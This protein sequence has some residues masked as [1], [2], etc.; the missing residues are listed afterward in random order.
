MDHDNKSD[1]FEALR[2]QA[3]ELIKQV[4]LEPHMESSH[5]FELIHELKQQQKALELQNEE[6][7]QKQREISDL[8]QEYENLY[9]LASIA[10]ISINAKGIITRVN[11]MAVQLLKT[12]RQ[13]LLRSGFSRFI[14]PEWQASYHASLKDSIKT[15]KKQRIELKLKTDSNHTLWVRADIEA[16]CD[17]AGQLL[18]WYLMLIDITLQKKTEAL[19]KKNQEELDAIYKNAPVLLMLVDKDRRVKKIN[20]YGEKLIGASAQDLI[21][22]RGGEAIRCLHQLHHPNGCGSQPACVPCPIN[23][24]V[25]DSFENGTTHEMKEV[26]LPLLKDNE[27]KE[28]TFLVSTVLLNSEEEREVL[29]S[30]V[31]IT[32]RKQM[33]K[34]LRE[35]EESYRSLFNNSTIAV[36]IT[37]FP[38]NI[39]KVNDKM[40]EISGYSHEELKKVSTDDI[41][42]DPNDR[43]KLIKTIKQ[44]GKVDNYECRIKDKE[45]EIHWAHMSV[46]II[47]YRGQ[48]ALLT[49]LIDITTVKE[50]EKSLRE[51]E[52]RYRTI[53]DNAP[54]GFHIRDLSQR[55]ID[56]NHASYHMHGYCRDEFMSLNINKYV[57]EKLLKKA[58]VFF[59]AIKKGKSVHAFGTNIKKDGT[60]FPVEVVVVPVSFNGKAHSLTIIQ[61]ISDREEA[62]KALMESNEKFKS[63]F[64]Q[65]PTDILIAGLDGTILDFNHDMSII[66]IPRKEIIG[67]K[68]SE[69]FRNKENNLNSGLNALFNP[70][71]SP[72]DI[73]I[74]TPS[75]AELILEVHPAETKFN[76]TEIFIFTILDITERR[77]TKDELKWSNALLSAMGRVARVGGWELN[78][79]T[80]EIWCTEETYRIYEVS[81]DYKYALP[82]LIDFYHPDEHKRIS[83]AIQKALK[84]GEPYDMELRFITAG[85]NPLWVRSICKPQIKSGKVIKLLGTIQDITELKQAEGNLIKKTKQLQSLTR[86][87]QSVREGERT[88]IAREIHDEFGQVLSALNMNLSTI[89]REVENNGK[90]LNRQEILSE[91]KQSKAILTTAINDVRKM[92]TELRPQVLDVF[93]LLPAIQRHLD[94]FGERNGIRTD[95]SSNIESINLD[96]DASIALFRIVQE[97]LTNIA[98]HAKAT[99]VNIV[100]EKCNAE[101][102]LTIRDNGL[103]FDLN[104]REQKQSFGLMGMEERVLLLKGELKIASKAGQ[105]TELFIKIPLPMLPH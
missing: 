47:N 38:G 93:G 11:Q 98:K 22:L 76:D 49:S 67:K 15:G 4:P 40:T 39:L 79:E 61:D 2:Q 3:E 36:S 75:G 44:Q 101:L 19:N 55:I 34:D 99:R 103:G 66:G 92:I 69:V 28:A 24:R 70:E 53:F 33:E 9:E 51:S 43:K 89:E 1:K 80:R 50:T 13:Y 81:P 63:L 46:K 64:T 8:K 83:N 96:N 7:R 32:E 68:I 86:H 37:S 65:S 85:G 31:D 105:G 52:E 78:A 57:G 59:E 20:R 95:I 6:L 88:A 71:T 16:N 77:K 73:E 90:A 29:I 27:K 42:V 62:K 54:I 100:I 104:V 87:L 72:I 25:L 58:A 35:S 97:A 30:M 74:K 12:D 41:Y 82:E 5:I 48:D 102:L 10:Y 17:E 60:E 21:G 14:A 45:G 26:S 91:L 23:N 18:R 84:N 56:A 94:E